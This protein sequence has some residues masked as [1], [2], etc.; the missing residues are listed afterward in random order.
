MSDAE[1]KPELEPGMS[2]QVLRPATLAEAR[3]AVRSG[4]RLLFRG[5]ATALD[6][7]APV[8]DVDVIVDTSGLDRLVQHNPGDMTAT[9]GAGMPLA[10]LQELL[11]PAGQWLALDPPGEGAGATVGGLL[12]CGESGP[13][14]QG[15]GALR[16]LVIG[17]TMVLADGSIARSGGQVIKNVAG[18]DLGKLLYGSLGTLGLVTEVVLRLHPRPPVS[19][20]VAAPATAGQAAAA[21]LDLL[22]SPLEPTAIEWTGR[23]LLVRFDGSEAGVRA[24]TA[25]APGLLRKRGLDGQVVED[26]V[27]QDAA[28]HV[29]GT[30]GETVVRAGTLPSRLPEVAD[31]LA[32]AADDAGV[33]ASLSSS[34]GLGL[35]TAAIAGGDAA[36]HA[37]CV[38]AWR[39]Q[40][41]E[42][43]GSVVLRRRAP[44]VD[45]LLDAWG[46]PPSS[47]V[48]LRAVKTRFDPEGRCGPGRFAPWFDEEQ[49]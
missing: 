8:S 38:D 1:A 27:W 4:S 34:A 28:T 14:R 49:T 16:D 6:W 22:A 25:D 19:R 40:V 37:A 36:G 48:L 46:P 23:R 7:G 26:A 43:G 2:G 15:Y 45:E 42:A 30:D 9:V 21:A 3:D 32:R 35:H 31:A 20:T 12:A 44:G 29:A 17:V 24:A 13:R 18:Y 5:G 10:R 41:L 39:K 11:A 33:V 47:V